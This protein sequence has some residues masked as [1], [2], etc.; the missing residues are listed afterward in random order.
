MG[1][2][3]VPTHLLGRGGHSLLHHDQ[4][5]GDVLLLHALAVHLDRLDPHFGLLWEKARPGVTESP[6]RSDPPSPKAQPDPGVPRKSLALRT[7]P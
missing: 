3:P 5:P 1:H 4:G 7:P 2:G 6:P